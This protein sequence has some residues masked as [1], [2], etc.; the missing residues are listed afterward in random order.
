MSRIERFEDLEAWKLARVL[1]GLIYNV[2]GI[3]EFSR[4]F[5]LRDQLRRASIS[6]V[7]NIAEGFE[8][9][10]DKELHSVSLD[11]KG[12]LRRGS[13]STLLGPRSWL[14]FSGTIC[15]TLQQSH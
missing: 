5:A 6:I 9:D 8:R 11:G 3:R 12:F 2:T 7:S 4:D 13:S 14:H 10:G 15:P 1:T